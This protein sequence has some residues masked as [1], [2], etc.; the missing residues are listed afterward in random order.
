[1]PIARLALWLSSAALVAMA[2]VA[3]LGGPVL[4]VAGLALL[5]L[6]Y[7]ALLAWGSMVPRLEMYG[8]VLWRVPEARGKVALTFDDGP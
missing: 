2:L 6:L 3:A 1:M 4:S 8:D 5:G 7:A